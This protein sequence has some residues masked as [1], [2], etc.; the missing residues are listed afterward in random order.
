VSRES[1]RESLF[2]AMLLAA[3]IVFYVLAHE[4]GCLP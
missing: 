4:W 1:D 3:V 2:G